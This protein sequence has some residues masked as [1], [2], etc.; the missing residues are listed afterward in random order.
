MPFANPLE[1]ATHFLRHGA[2][3]GCATEDEYEELAEDFLF[4]AMDA[5][6]KECVRPKGKDRLRF[7]GINRNF[8]VA[9]VQ[10]AFVRTFY[11]VRLLKIQ[12]HGGPDAFFADECARINL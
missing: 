3:F 7:R 8:G 12:R 11:R 4:G 2:Q 1:R 6:T 5:G 9:C 10:P